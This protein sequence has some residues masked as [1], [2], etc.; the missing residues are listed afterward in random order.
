MSKSSRQTN[1]M[2]RLQEQLASGMKTEKK[3]FNKIPLTD[4]DVKRINKEMEIL[5]KKLV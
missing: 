4:K 1:A 3:G 2:K 5:K